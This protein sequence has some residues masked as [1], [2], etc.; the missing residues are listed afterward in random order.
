MPDLPE[1]GPREQQPWLH[2]L[3]VALRAG[4]VEVVELEAP[5]TA[6]RV[7]GPDDVRVLEALG[8]G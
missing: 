5:S 8:E 4:G 3:V 7:S 2:D 6:G 1:S